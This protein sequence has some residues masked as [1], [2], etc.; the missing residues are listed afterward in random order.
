MEQFKHTFSIIGLAE[1]NTD[2]STSSLY[3]IPNFNSFYQDTQPNKKKGT[4]VALYIHKSLN[5]TIND[6]LSQITPNL[7][8]LFVTISN[9]NSPVTVGVLYRPPS[10]DLQKALDEISNLLDNA[11]KSSVYIM[12]DYNIDLHN[13]TSTIVNSFEETILTAG[14]TPLISLD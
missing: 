12:G 13:H 2:S 3:T 7:E 10:G 1:T 6:N 9:N 4:G 14:F 11:A 5:A 8:T